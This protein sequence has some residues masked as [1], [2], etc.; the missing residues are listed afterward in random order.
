MGEALEW[1]PF[2]GTVRRP[3]PCCCGVRCVRDSRKRRREPLPSS[4]CVGGLDITVRGTRVSSEGGAAVKVPRFT[5][6]LTKLTNN[7]ERSS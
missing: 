4:G 2:V 1:V 3:F 7:D 6:E 5:D